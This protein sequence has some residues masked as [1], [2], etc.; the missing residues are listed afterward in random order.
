MESHLRPMSLGEILDRTAL[1]Y[2]TNFPVLAGIASVYAGVLL[3]VGLAQTGMQ[4]WL[5]DRNMS[6]AL[7]WLSGVSVLLTWIVIFIVGGIAV[8]ANNRAVAWLQMGEPATI[9]EA[10]RG[11]LPKIAR[12]LWLMVLK[13]VFAWSPV[14]VIYAGFLLLIAYF[15]M[16]GWMERGGGSPSGP[17]ALVFFAIMG[18]LALASLPAFVYG[19]MMALRYA[20]AVPACVVE[21]LKAR[22]A[23]RRSIELT[24]FSRGRIFVLWL[25]VGVIAFG[26]AGVSQSFFIWE[27]FKHHLRLPLGLRILQQ[28]VGFCTTTFIAPMLA[29]GLTL[30]YYDQ[31]VRKEG[32]DIEWMMQAAGMTAQPAGIAPGHTAEPRAEDAP[33]RAAEP[34]S[35]HE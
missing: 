22:A 16:K 29:T 27:T 32:F 20:L 3:A 13:T 31:R 35:A 28:L 14:I 26:L 8:A 2:R 10:Y 17:E 4:E 30:F 25:L 19:V 5:L 7:L 34:G 21:N 11:I 23:I 18:V 24:R 12:Y 33:F 9:R 15:K 6:R 1:L